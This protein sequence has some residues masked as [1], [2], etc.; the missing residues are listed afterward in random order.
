MSRLHKIFAVVAGLLFIFAGA[1]LG[2]TYT[3]SGVSFGFVNGVPMGHEW[4]T[5]MA[6]IELLGYTPA[7]APDI[8]DPSD[9]RKH[10]TQGL[11][12]NTSLSG[13]R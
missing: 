8:P 5:R 13:G 6:A 12:K 11:A 2:W 3:Q 7:T 4:V 10:W 1:R 9:P